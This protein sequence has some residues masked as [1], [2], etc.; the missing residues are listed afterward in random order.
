MWWL[1][2]SISVIS[3]SARLSARAAATPANPP[4]TI[5]TRFLSGTAAFVK[6]GFSCGNDLVRTVVMDVPMVLGPPGPIALVY[7]GHRTVLGRH[8]GGIERACLI[9][10][11]RAS[12]A[13]TACAGGVVRTSWP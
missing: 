9:T 8:C 1:R 2:R 6:G 3:T 12:V 7:G 13:R 5:K 11:R 10:R 4:P